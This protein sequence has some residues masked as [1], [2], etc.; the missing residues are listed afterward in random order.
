MIFAVTFG[1]QHLLTVFLNPSNNIGFA[2]DCKAD[3]HKLA[4]IFKYWQTAL[5]Y[6]D[7]VPRRCFC[8]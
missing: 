3:T 1:P 4:I 2:G 6:V 5:H 7:T 8:F